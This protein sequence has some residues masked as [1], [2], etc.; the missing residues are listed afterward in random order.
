M[1]KKGGGILRD[2]DSKVCQR[3][4]C[5][6]CRQQCWY[7]VRGTKRTIFLLVNTRRTNRQ[8]SRPSVATGMSSTI[9]TG[10]HLTGV[11]IGVFTQAGNYYCLYHINYKKGETDQ[12]KGKCGHWFNQTNGK[13]NV[14]IHKYYEYI[15]PKDEQCRIYTIEP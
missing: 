9:V 4:I 1:N 5:R 14:S 7:Q 11:Y 2:H 13:E 10:W 3:T 15:F 8:S 12:W 6:L